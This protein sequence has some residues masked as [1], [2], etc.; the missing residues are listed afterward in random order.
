MVSKDD[1]TKCPKH[2]AKAVAWTQ[3]KE[4]PILELDL[5][6]ETRRCEYMRVDPKSG[7]KMRCKLMT[8]KQLPMCWHHT[9]ATYKVVIR[10][11]SGNRGLGL[12]ACDKTIEGRSAPVFKAGDKIAIYARRSKGPVIGFKASGKPYTNEDIERKYGCGLA[13]Y[14]VHI[15]DKNTQSV[16]TAQQRSIGSYAN[17]TTSHKNKSINAD[18]DVVGGDVWILAEKN[19]YN[20][21]EIVYFYGADYFKEP[22]VL[23]TRMWHTGRSERPQKCS[24][25]RRRRSHER[26]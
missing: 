22:K 16:D 8:K 5:P 18:L 10:P 17:G 4:R 14:A 25:K 7:A 12:F 15:D 23:E 1:P 13:A 21:D 26:K 20:G 9:P 2:T 11:A 24:P 6:L 19:I 3:S